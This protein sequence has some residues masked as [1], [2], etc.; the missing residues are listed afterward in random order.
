M[1]IDLFKRQVDWHLRRRALITIED[2]GIEDAV[3]RRAMESE[4]EPLQMVKDFIEE[5]GID[6]VTVDPWIG[7]SKEYWREWERNNPYPVQSNNTTG[8]GRVVSI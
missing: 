5:A 2:A 7:P 8:P 4:V 6:D 1:D 3:L